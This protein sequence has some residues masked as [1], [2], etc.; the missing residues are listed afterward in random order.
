MRYFA[1]VVLIILLPACSIAV[2]DIEIEPGSY[3]TEQYIEL[4][5]GKSIAV[6]ANH[7]SQIHNVHIIDT[8]LKRGLKISKIFSPEHGFQGI[9]EAGSDINDGQY[10][11]SAISVISL[12][13][14]K[15]KPSKYDMQ[16]LDFV[17]FDLQDVG[18]RFYTYLS[19]L[20]NVMEACAENN[21]PLIVLDRPNPNGFYVDGPILQEEFRSFI[22]MHTVPIVYGMTIGEYALM[23]NGEGWLKDSVQCD[24][25]VIR[26]QNYEHSYYYSLPVNPSPNLRE[27]KAIYLYPS[28]AFFEGTIVSEG[29]GTD[30]P[31]L[32][33]GHPD[34]PDQDF[35]FTPTK[36]K[37]GAP[38]PKWNEKVCYGIDLRMLSLDSLKNK[39]E[40]D[41]HYLINMYNVLA[42]GTDFFIDYFDLL[43]GNDNLRKQIIKGESVENIKK[44]WQSD[45]E[46]F[47]KI[48][49]KYL[50]YPE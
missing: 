48:R 44:T 28:M 33:A 41:L 26:C 20:H 7:T 19:T 4:L 11:K 34:Y 13:G 24:L 50:L 1:F 22:G 2:N 9:A 38:N 23:I 42:K 27:M 37:R 5:Q 25:S 47:K 16:G 29:R 36:K 18:V 14:S 30:F 32:F 15:K 43:A 45:L 17:I 10:I 39:K 40:I 12:Y 31:F 3:Q 6:V 46:K 8:L 35:S 21:I 49:V